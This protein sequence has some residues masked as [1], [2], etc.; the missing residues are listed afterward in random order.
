MLS[1]NSSLT[2]NNLFIVGTYDQSSDDLFDIDLARYLSD[3][4]TAPTGI[5]YKRSNPLLNPPT[6]IIAPDPDGRLRIHVADF[7]GPET[8]SQLQNL[9][10][11]LLVYAGGR[12][13]LRQPLLDVARHGCIGGHY[14]HL[15]EVRGMATVEWSVMLGIAPTVA[16][17]RISSGI[18]TGNIIMQAKVPLVAGDTYTSIRDRSYFLTKVML[19][20]SASGILHKKQQGTPQNIDAGRQYFRLHPEIQTRADLLLDRL[21]SNLKPHS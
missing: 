13:I 4:G 14:G 21:L 3:V 16:I 5:V 1:G 2:K 15:P 9:Q 10:P 18:D 20:I 7:N 19:A 17:Q 12:D 8:V 6:P 11:D